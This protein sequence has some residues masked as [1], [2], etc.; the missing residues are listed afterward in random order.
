[1]SA[2][3]SRKKGGKLSV[4]S[5]FFTFCLG[6]EVFSGSACASV[7]VK[8]ELTP[9]EYGVKKLEQQSKDPFPKEFIEALLKSYDDSRRDP[10]ISK[11]ILGF[12]YRAD[13][14]SHFS[15]R[16][17]KKCEKFIKK[18]EAQLRSAEER[19]GVSPALIAAL[20][21]VES[22]H[23]KRT[24]SYPVASVY[25]SLLQSD[26]PMM[27]KLTEDSVRAEF[28]HVSAADFSKIAERSVTKSQWALRQLHALSA[29]QKKGD[30]F[31]LRGSYAGAFGFPQF[32]P[33]S[34]VDWAVSSQPGQ[35][36]DLFKMEDAIP[37][38]GNYLYK[39]GWKKDLPE[40]QR[41]ALKHY[42]QSDGYVNVILQLEAEILRRAA[43]AKQLARPPILKPRPIGSY[44]RQASR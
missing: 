43:L 27:I 17:V 40:A 24:G 6:L 7:S 34:Y 35:E 16:A 11:N 20:L 3:A 29:M 22:K 37:S 32:V 39:N 13:Y 12:L 14:S 28:P 42:N 4:Q 26:H 8:H 31:A 19:Y 9:R 44:T 38:T 30:V 25:F 1:M 21:W 18:Y 23:G 36:A 10:V 33:S 41:A 2:Q 15:P 5:I